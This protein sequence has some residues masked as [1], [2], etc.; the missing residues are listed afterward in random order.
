MNLPSATQ[1]KERNVRSGS[2]GFTLLEVSL[3]KVQPC[4]TIY[5]NC[6]RTRGCRIRAPYGQTHI[7]FCRSF[8]RYSHPTH[9][10]ERVWGPIMWPN[11]V[12][13]GIWQ[14]SCIEQNALRMHFSTSS[15]VLY[16]NTGLPKCSSCKLIVL[17]LIYWM[18]KNPV[19]TAFSYIVLNNANVIWS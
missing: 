11:N 10:L 4:S 8:L 6:C 7:K 18:N 1:R 12:H 2:F 19:L 9:R 3:Q 13:R 16:V 14:N 5:S 17:L 15:F